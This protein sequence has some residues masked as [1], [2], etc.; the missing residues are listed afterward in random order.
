MPGMPVGGVNGVELYYEVRGDD[1]GVPLL[2]VNGLGSQC[3]SWDAELLDAF[4]DRGFRVVIF[5]NRDVGLSTWLDTPDLKVGDE[6]AKAI[7]GEAVDAP[8]RLTDMAADAVGLL[9]LLGI[10][11][12]HIVGVSMGGM[13]VQTVAIE[14]P[15]RVLSLTSIMSTTGERDVGHPTPE[16]GAALFKPAATSRDEAIQSHVDSW[17]VIGTPAAFDEERFRARGA[18]FYDRAFNPAGVG[19][20]MLAVMASGSRAEG[21]AKVAT[22]TLVIH[23]EVDPLVGITGGKRTADLVPGSTF[24]E[25]EG[26]GHEIAPN[27]RTQI[28]D[29]ITRHAASATSPGGTR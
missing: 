25:I 8:Y 17:R 19:R 20:Q 1:D 27:D 13:I 10:D 6:V 26:M 28:V 5:D 21:L 3:I 4:V 18:A 22:P 23:G 24:V 7:S 14:H 2:L 9:D 15:D 11:A 16:A 12:A 29:V